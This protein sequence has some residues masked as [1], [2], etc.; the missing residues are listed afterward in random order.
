MQGHLTAS[1]SLRPFGSGLRDADLR[2]VVASTDVRYRQTLRAVI[3][4]RSLRGAESFVALAAELV[5]LNTRAN[6]DVLQAE[7][8]M[9]DPAGAL[10]MFTAG[11]VGHLILESEV[12]HERVML[13]AAG[14][15]DFKRIEEVANLEQIHIA[16]DDRGSWVCRVI[17]ADRLDDLLDGRFINLDD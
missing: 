13:T 3:V 12:T 8:H 1:R 11:D 5:V 4:R 6:L 2:L 9:L 16:T 15:A 14:L 10:A 17:D 7:A